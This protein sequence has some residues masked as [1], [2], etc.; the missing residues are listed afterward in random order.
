MKSNLKKTAFIVFVFINALLVFGFS[1]ETKINYLSRFLKDKS[2]VFKMK[3]PDFKSNNSKS[4]FV[5]NPSSVYFKNLLSKKP[6]FRKGDLVIGYSNPD[7]EV[8][9]SGQQVI[10][11]DIILLNN[12]K[13]RFENADIVLYGDIMVSDNSRLEV[14]DSSLSIV[15]KF[16]YSNEMTIYGTGSVFFQGDTVN[17][18]GFNWGVVIAESGVWQVYDTDFENGVTTSIFGNAVAYV[19]NSNPVEWV[20]DG[21]SSLTLK[22]C[23]GPFMLWPVFNNGAVADITFPDGEN[24]NYFEIS[25]STTGISNIGIKLIID[26]CRNVLWGMLVKKGA[27]VTVRDSQMKTTGIIADVGESWKITGLTNEQY[28][29]DYTLPVSEVSVRYVNTS[30]DVF[31]IYQI[32]AEEVNL[33][34]SVV[35]ELGVLSGTTCSVWKTMIDGTGGYFFTNSNAV[36]SFFLSTLLSHAVSNQQS[37]DIFINSTILGGDIIARDSSV[38]LLANT[39]HDNVP[40]AY[41]SAFVVDASLYLPVSESI[42][43]QVPIYGAAFVYYGE[44]S[45]VRLESYSLSYSPSGEENWVDI[46]GEKSDAVENGVLGFW[47]TTG[48]E[49]GYYTVKLTVNLNYGEPIE[50]VKVIFLGFKGT[51][52]GTFFIPHIDNGDYWQSYLVFDN[53]SQ[54]YKRAEVYLF[55]N[56][57][58]L[59]KVNVDLMPFEQR[60]V[61]LEGESGFVRVG[62]DVSV[63]EFFVSLLE[64]GIAQFYLEGVS[65]GRISC[66]MPYYSSDILTWEGVAFQNTRDI[67]SNVVLKAY[68]PDGLIIEEGSLDLNPLS[69][70]AGVIE[71]YF[72]QVEYSNL[73]RVDVD[74]DTLLNGIV[75]SGKGNKAL[76]FTKAVSTALEGKI[77]IP[78]IANEWNIWDNILVFDNLTDSVKEVSLTL[79][80]NGQK[81]LDGKVYRLPPNSQITVNL[82]DFKNLSPECGYVDIDSG[83]V[84]VRQGY[85]AAEGGVAEFL[86]S[87]NS[88]QALVLNMPKT[89]EEKLNWSGCALMNPD[90]GEVS[91]VLNAYNQGELIDSVEITI[92]S[93]QRV[94][95]VLKDFFPSIDYTVVDRIE[96]ISDKP[97]T[98]LTISGYNQE[99]LLFSNPFFK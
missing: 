99:M 94:V 25:D 61:F 5:F 8:V 29:S 34:N 26:N 11:G 50:V 80:S 85:K 60:R 65:S 21:L 51:T 63:R 66:L 72:S 19:E 69:K 6:D 82:N 84:A 20:V 71:N 43:S 30:V 3:K 92:P 37:I 79:Y 62:E 54:L 16:I 27:D 75:I 93:N 59:K 81:V 86:L 78:H 17:S 98:G 67:S 42:D 48:I 88:S 97:L 18:N 23:P 39:T 22:N 32:G 7:E 31:N 33:E 77:L 38:I 49:P 35:G 95:G 53:M 90:N 36:T 76:L 74:S 2:Y 1:P 9:L 55:E 40:E 15:S 10:S 68:S 44:E 24:V 47:N 28:F 89:E 46:A 57:S 87:S 96:I 64:G 58:F 45:P 41:D 83:G 56:G 70:S 14:V 52:K 73:S 91:T 13:L 12:G 4:G